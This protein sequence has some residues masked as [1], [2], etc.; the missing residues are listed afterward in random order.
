MSEETLHCEASEQSLQLLSAC[1]LQ[2]SSSCWNPW[3]WSKVKSKRGKG[4]NK[5]FLSCFAL[6][7]QISYLISFPRI[8]F[9]GTERMWEYGSNKRSSYKGW[10]E[11]VL[12]T[13][14]VFTC[15]LL[16]LPLYGIPFFIPASF[17]PPCPSMF[18]NKV[19]TQK[20]SL[21][22]PSTTVNSPE[23]VN[24]ALLPFNSMTI[25]LAAWV[26]WVQPHPRVHG[27]LLWP[28][29]TGGTWEDRSPCNK[30]ILNFHLLCY[31]YLQGEE[32][33]E[34]RHDWGRSEENAG[35]SSQPVDAGGQKRRQERWR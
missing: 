5:G 30:I 1:C 11:Q 22:L 20:W 16:L 13:M 27:W 25:T 24:R 29:A 8:F 2:P 33:D 26:I 18:W 9:P 7:R 6:L 12:S 10:Y 21:A 19:S 35:E 15:S 17:S 4:G 32:K 23:E 28:I 3:A 31:N 14:S 34:R